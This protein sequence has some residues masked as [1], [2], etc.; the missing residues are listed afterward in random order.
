M[1]PYDALPYWMALAITC[2]GCYVLNFTDLLSMLSELV[3]YRIRKGAWFWENYGWGSSSVLTLVGVGFS[4][5]LEA[6]N[7]KLEDRTLILYFILLNDII[8]L[9]D[10]W[11]P[12]HSNSLHICYNKVW[13]CIQIQMVVTIKRQILVYF[14]AD[15]C[16]VILR[17]P[18]HLLVWRQFFVRQMKSA[19][20]FAQNLPIY[21]QVIYVDGKVL[22]QY[23]VEKNNNGNTIT[24]GQCREPG[25]STN[26]RGPV[27]TEADAKDFLFTDASPHIPC[28]WPI[29]G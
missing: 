2:L 17:P 8:Q 28:L 23:A 20:S 16:T 21:L 18:L 10:L 25:K 1:V 9:N 5:W 14:A 7:L 12:R 24:Q 4:G 6:V 3:G 27:V 26:A 22:K 15:D 13:P 29:T 19:Y 11:V